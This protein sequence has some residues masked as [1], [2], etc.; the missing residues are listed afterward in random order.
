MSIK[1]AL[2]FGFTI[3]I[4]LVICTWLIGHLWVFIILISTTLFGIVVSTIKE[5]KRVK[6][7]VKQQGHPS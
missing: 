7:Q 2:L 1:K 3:A 4:T 6:Q 5:K